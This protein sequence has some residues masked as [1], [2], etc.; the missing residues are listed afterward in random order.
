MATKNTA[1]F[2]IRAVEFSDGSCVREQV[3]MTLRDYFA[4]AAITGLVGAL[5][6]K[7]PNLEDIAHN[8]YKL[9][10]AMIAERDLAP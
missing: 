6:G 5:Q 2:P 3:G 8:A 9:A 7:K 10:D 4:A 1:A